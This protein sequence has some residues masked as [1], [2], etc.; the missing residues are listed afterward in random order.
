MATIVKVILTHAINIQKQKKL[1]HFGPMM[2]TVSIDLVCSKRGSVT[3][4]NYV[5]SLFTQ[6]EKSKLI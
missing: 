1:Y 4:K 6:N 5:K 3:K 2:A